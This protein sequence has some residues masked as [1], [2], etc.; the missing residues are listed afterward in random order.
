M[1]KKL[2]LPKLKVK[3]WKLVSEYVRRKDADNCG[4]VRCYTCGEPKFWK[5]VDA[6]HAIGGRNNAV[7]FDEEIIRPQCK[8][9]NMPPNCG[10]YYE[11]GIKLN[12]ENG[13]GWYEAKKIASKQVVK[14]TRSDLEEM[15]EVKK[16]QLLTIE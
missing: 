4:T 15:I 10:M 2:T 3:L 5:E 13:D 12:Q 14:F 11:F 1:K 9:C 8:P 16:A 7:L 6:G